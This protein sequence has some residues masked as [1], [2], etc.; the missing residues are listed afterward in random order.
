MAAATLYAA[1]TVEFNAR[2]V[3]LNFPKLYA[4]IGNRLRKAGIGLAL[5][6]DEKDDIELCEMRDTVRG[7]VDLKVDDINVHGSFKDKYA[8]WLTADGL[9]Y[10]KRV[11]ANLGGVE[12][13]QRTELTTQMLISRSRNAHACT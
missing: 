4:Q 3:T 10:V 9:K 13:I 1:T 12:Q 2:I 8:D 7:I 11:V 5:S 6:F